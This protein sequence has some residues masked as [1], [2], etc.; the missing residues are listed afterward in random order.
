MSLRTLSGLLLTL[1]L[2]GGCNLI[3]KQNIQQ[4]NALEQEDLDELYIG[5]NQRQVL[6]VLGTPS[7]RDPFHAD[8]WGTGRLC[9]IRAA[10]AHVPDLAGLGCAVGP[11]PSEDKPSEP[12]GRLGAAPSLRT[13]RHL[14]LQVGAEPVRDPVEKVE[15]GDRHETGRNE[16]AYEARISGAAERET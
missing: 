2:L 15:E 10:R 16:P 13:R 12:L 4:G 11:R 14:G 9:S 7:I 8:R 1:S 3:Y 5:M 6:F